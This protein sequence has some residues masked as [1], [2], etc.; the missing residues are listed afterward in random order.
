MLIYYISAELALQ[1]RIA[2]DRRLMTTQFYEL[3]KYGFVD[4][5]S[6]DTKIPKVS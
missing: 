3:V 5:I 1:K 2:V 4:K 6:L